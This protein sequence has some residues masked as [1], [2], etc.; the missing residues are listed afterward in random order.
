MSPAA[1]TPGW[2]VDSKVG[3]TATKP[4][5]SRARP[6]VCVCEGGGGLFCLSFLWGGGNVCVC[7]CFNTNH[8]ASIHIHLQ[9]DR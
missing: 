9:T 7:V 1:K 2:L 3:K 6:F 4:L 5:A 8:P